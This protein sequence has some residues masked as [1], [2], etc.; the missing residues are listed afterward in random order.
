[1]WYCIL[2]TSCLCIKVRAQFLLIIHGAR[3]SS[4]LTLSALLLLHSYY[5]A[6]STTINKE[7]TDYSYGEVT[8]LT[9]K[10]T[11]P[12]AQRLKEPTSPNIHTPCPF[13]VDWIYRSAIAYHDV[14]Q[15]DDTDAINGYVQT[16]REAMEELGRYWGVG[17][18]VSPLSIPAIFAPSP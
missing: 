12:I 6:T 13:L 2:L 7:E 8:K 1:M 10:V 18:N 16:M 15:T 17:G 5:R 9:S 4:L 3:N 14:H 11:L